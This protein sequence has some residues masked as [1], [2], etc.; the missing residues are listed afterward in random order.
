MSKEEHYSKGMECFSD[1]HLN[2]A[3]QELEKAVKLDPKYGDALHALAMCYYH[4]EDIDNALKWGKRFLEVEPSNPLAYTSL[5][6][7][8]N[9]KGMIEEAE[10]M[11][12]K[13]RTADQEDNSDSVSLT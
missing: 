4:Q 12:A 9:A 2:M 10:E 1:D 8:F 7:F 11:V 5:S 13:A 6:I 3:V